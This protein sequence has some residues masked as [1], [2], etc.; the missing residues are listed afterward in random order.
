MPG[1]DPGI[2]LLGKRFLRRGWIAGSSPAMTG[3]RPKL[4]IPRETSSSASAADI[5]CARIRRRGAPCDPR[6][7]ATEQG[8]ETCRGAPP[9]SDNATPVIALQRARQTRSL[10]SPL[11]GGSPAEAQQR[12]AGWGW[13][14]E[15]RAAPQTTTPTPSPSPQGGGEHTE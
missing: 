12:R 15:A 1:L 11:W 3:L 6:G 5:D 13:C 14:S 9:R 8:K 4:L 2:H 10:P 7:D